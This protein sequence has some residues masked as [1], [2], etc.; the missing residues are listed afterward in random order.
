MTARTDVLEIPGYPGRYNTRAAIEAWQNAGSPRF[1]DAGRFRETQLELW[2]GW[3]NRR[4]GFYPADNPDN[5]NLPRAHMRMV[6]C[7]IARYSD[8]EAMMRAGFVFPYDGK[9]G[10]ANEWWHAEL[11]NLYEFPIVNKR[12]I[13]RPEPPNG[14]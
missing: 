7:D 6:A 4:P 3:K 2:E 9:N 8:R 13:Y 1:T 14:H 10:R 5:P 11:P 12:D